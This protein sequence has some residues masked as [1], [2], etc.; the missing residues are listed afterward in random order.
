MKTI[1]II[2][3]LSICF[4]L[5]SREIPDTLWTHM[6]GSSGTEELF[7]MKETSDN[8]FILAGY[9]DFWGS[10]SD[11][12]YLIKCDYQGV[13]EWTGYYGSEGIDTAY[14]VIETVDGGFLVLGRTDNGGTSFF[15]LCLVKINSNGV[16]QW[17]QTYGGAEPEIGYS[18]VND[19]NGGYVIT[20]VT[21]S[22][23][24]GNGDVWLLKVDE[25]VNVVWSNTFGGSN[26]D[27]GFEVKQVS[28]NGFVITGIT[29][30]TAGYSENLYL[31]KTDENGDL[32]W[33][34]D[35]GGYYFDDGQDV[36]EGSDGGYLVAGSYKNSLTEPADVWL[37]KVDE[38]GEVEWDN[39]YGGLYRDVAYSV[40]E[41]SENDYLIS[42]G[43]FVEQGQLNS[44]I[45]LLKTTSQGEEIWL[46][47]YGTPENE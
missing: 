37:I 5:F 29:S 3:I 24:E 1:L 44:E 28:D 34:K 6:Y 13:T 19:V 25:A 12:M 9:T 45:F 18:I 42:G 10:G 26:L 33:E 14:S 41:N 39:T 27:I 47:T 36:I 7:D 21:N 23:G 31:V 20:G 35:L 8:G 43:T 32:E 16:E 38:T 15:D 22:F 4:S 17:S 40:I 46:E 11:D 2:S 30:S